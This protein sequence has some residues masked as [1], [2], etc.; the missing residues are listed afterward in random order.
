MP[1]T[2]KLKMKPKTCRRAPNSTGSVR[3]RHPQWPRQ[4]SG[5]VGSPKVATRATG[6]RAL[7]RCGLSWLGHEGTRRAE[8]TTAT[9]S[10]AGLSCLACAGEAPGPQK[11]LGAESGEAA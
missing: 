7:R 10:L 1:S 9:K 2:A 8:K 3:I 6:K 5:R 4:V 11:M